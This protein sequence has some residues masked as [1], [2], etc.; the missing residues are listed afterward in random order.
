M[1]LSLSFQEFFLDNRPNRFP[2]FRGGDRPCC[3]QV[4]ET[5]AE[6]TN[7]YEASGKFSIAVV[8]SNSP[9]HLESQ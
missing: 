2:T 9:R 7:I 8:A 3:L 1:L 6:T 4:V 5:I